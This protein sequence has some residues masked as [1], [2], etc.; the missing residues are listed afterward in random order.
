[1]YKYIKIVFF[2]SILLLGSCSIFNEYERPAVKTEGY[3]IN[4]STATE[5]NSTDTN[6]FGNLPWRSLFTDNV[7]QSL[8]DEALKN[9]IDLQ[10]AALSVQQA[11]AQLSSAQL[12]FLPSFMFAPSGTLSS[13]DGGKVR[14]TYSLPIQASWNVDLFGS[15]INGKRAAQVVLLQSKDYQIAVQ[16]NLIANIANAYYTLLMLDKQLA[17]TRETADL[18][19]HTWDMM[20]AQKDYGNG[21]EASVLSAK[22]NYYA[23][24]ASI[25]ELQRQITVTENVL[26]LLLGKSA[27]SIER[28]TL[29]EQNLPTEF[30]LGVPVQLLANRPDVHAAEMNLAYCFYQTNVARAAFYPVLNIT[31]S[32]AWTNNSGAGIVDPAKILATAVGSL[33]QP[34]FQNGKLVSALKV[35]KAE[36]EKAAL[37]WQFTVLNAGA[38]VS[39]ALALYKASVEKS[40]HEAIRIESLKSN[41]SIAQ[42]LFNMQPSSTYLEVVTAQQLL[43]SAQLNKISDDFNKMQAVVNLYYALGGGRY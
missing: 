23:V 42:D 27:T 41:V 21:T 10:T 11:E 9:N 3:R 34:I 6:N 43:L 25:P 31:A 20:T 26:S 24:L 7:L 14:A 18:T 17:L 8:I 4:D 15:L 28:N 22:A 16:T 5:Q 38:E 33:L 35:A 1:M 40:Q 36:Q 13:W 32:A 39:N 37:N 19:K 30:A 2:S 29:D 12:S